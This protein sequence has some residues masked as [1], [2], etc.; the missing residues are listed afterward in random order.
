MGGCPGTRVGDCMSAIVNI[1]FRCLTPLGLLSKVDSDVKFLDQDFRGNVLCRRQSRRTWGPTLY[2]DWVMG[3]KSLGQREGHR[4][5][6]GTAT[7][8]PSYITNPFQ[9]LHIMKIDLLFK[10]KHRI[11]LP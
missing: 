4:L 11:G 6:P 2:N 7:Q 1:S 8:V 10:Q 3:G 9:T 5:G